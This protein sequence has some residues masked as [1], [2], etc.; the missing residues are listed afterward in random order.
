MQSLS[1][2][3]PPPPPVG[4]ASIPPPGIKIQSIGVGHLGPC[5]TQTCCTWFTRGKVGYPPPGSQ[6]CPTHGG[7]QSEPGVWTSL[8][9]YPGTPITGTRA[10]TD[11][12]EKIPGKSRT[13]LEVRG[14]FPAPPTHAVMALMIHQQQPRCNLNSALRKLHPHPLLLP[15]CQPCPCSQPLIR[16]HQHPDRRLVWL[17]SHTR[18]LACIFPEANPVEE[19]F[20]DAELPL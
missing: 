13:P 17:A 9:P 15:K 16:I 20:K 19:A 6:L 7:A 4:A 5:G 12:S 10:A 8:T 14:G 11:V 18:H 3:A 1:P 2:S